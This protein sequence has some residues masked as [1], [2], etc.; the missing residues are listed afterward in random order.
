[1][2][3]R[4]KAKNIAETAARRLFMAVRSVGVPVDGI[5]IDVDQ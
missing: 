4:E 5:F 1:M 2:R 3:Y